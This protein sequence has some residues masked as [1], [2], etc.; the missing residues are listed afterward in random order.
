MRKTALRRKKIKSL[1]RWHRLSIRQKKKI[2]KK[3]YA[4]EARANADTVARSHEAA[5]DAGSRHPVRD[6]RIAGA[7]SAASDA[8]ARKSR[9]ENPYI[10]EANKNAKA[11]IGEAKHELSEMDK[12][13]TEHYKELYHFALAALEK[14]P[15]DEHVSP[16]LEDTNNRKKK[17]RG[18][19]Q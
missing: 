17:Q 6:A 12:E 11:V 2:I 19:N 16:S 13:I 10:K 4:E 14:S 5:V 9:S 3:E 1:R 18:E 15:P 7:A 8:D